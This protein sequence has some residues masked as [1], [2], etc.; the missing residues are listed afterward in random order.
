[1]CEVVAAH[2]AEASRAHGKN[3]AIW[4]EN[5]IHELITL[6]RDDYS[7]LMAVIGVLSEVS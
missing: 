1:M 3:G 7:T 2:L 5:A 4:K 6:L